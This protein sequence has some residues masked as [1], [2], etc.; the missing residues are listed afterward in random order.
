MYSW[1]AAGERQECI[2]G[3]EPANT[4]ALLAANIA[5]DHCPAIIPLPIDA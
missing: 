1:Y 5:E 2:P 4:R 3:T